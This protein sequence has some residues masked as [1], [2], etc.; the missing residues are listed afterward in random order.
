MVP[1]ETNVTVWDIAARYDN[2]FDD[3]KV[4]GAIAYSEPADDQQLYDGSISILHD[5]SGISLTV[6]AAYSDEAGDRRT[7]R[8][9]EAGLS[10]R[11]L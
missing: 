3:F 11:F 1:D 9:R 2:T 6:A 8:L 4:S 10:G 7:V 5:P